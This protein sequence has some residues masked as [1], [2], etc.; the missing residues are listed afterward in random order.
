MLSLLDVDPMAALA[1]DPTVTPTVVLGN[2]TRAKTVVMIPVRKSRARRISIFMHRNRSLRFSA[3]RS[4][5]CCL[6]KLVDPI[7]MRYQSK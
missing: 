3:R 1:V 5:F 2:D 4:C 7:K 6:F